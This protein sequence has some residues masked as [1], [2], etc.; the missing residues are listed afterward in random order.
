MEPSF[1][2]KV[3]LAAILLFVGATSAVLMWNGLATEFA[4]GGA[5]RREMRSGRA[6]F[7]VGVVGVAV[8]IWI[9]LGMLT[10]AW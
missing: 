4:R 9:A 2:N 7:V 8:A 3:L 5:T 6:R 1:A 10:H